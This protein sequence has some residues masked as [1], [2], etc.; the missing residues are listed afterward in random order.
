MATSRRHRPEFSSRPFWTSTFIITLITAYALFLRPAIQGENAHGSTL[1]KRVEDQECRL[2]H[3]AKDQCAFILANCQDDEAG[4]LQYL[5]FYYC[6][7]GNVQPLAFVILVVWMGMLFTTIGIA[8]S[9]FFS[10]NLSTIAS[11][12]GL[13]E[14]LAGVTFLAFGNGSPDV[15]STFAAMGSNSGSMAVGELIGAAGF[16][17]AV[18]AGSMALVR[19]F[20]VSRK[21]FVRDI[22]FFIAAVSFAM[23]FLADG[24]LNLWECMVMI[25]FYVFYVITVVGWHWLS[26]RRRRRR[27]KEAT[28]RSHFNGTGTSTDELEPYRDDPEDDHDD[29]GDGAPL[30]QRRSAT[31]DM[32]QL[33]RGPLISIIDADAAADEDAE[34]D[35]SR[36]ITAEMTSS[37]R[38]NRPLGRRSNTL[39]T[40]IRPSLV[41]VLEFRSIL[42]SLQKSGNVHLAPL[43]RSYTDLSRAGGD[44]S[45]ASLGAIDEADPFNAVGQGDGSNFRDRALSSGA[46]PL[47]L[48][49]PDLPPPEIITQSPKSPEETT[50]ADTLT[51]ESS[52]VR[53]AAPTGNIAPSLAA[54]LPDTDDRPNQSAQAPRS[55]VLQLQIPSPHGHSS[56]HSSPLGSPFPRF[57]ESP[58][59]MTGGASRTTTFSLPTPALSEHAPFPGIEEHRMPKPVRWWPYGILPPPHV[60]FCT[61]F[62]TLQGWREKNI[63]DKFVSIVSIPSIF[64]LVTTLPV[65]ESEADHDDDDAEETL[66]DPPAPG[67]PGR[68]GPPV[69]VEPH[70]SI[71]PE[72]EW[73][74][75]RRSTRSGSRPHSL[76]TSPGHSPMIAPVQAFSDSAPT[77]LPQPSI[78]PAPG[79]FSDPQDAAP[80]EPSGWNRWLVV[81]QLFTGPLFTVFII[82]ANMEESGRMLVKLVLYSLLFSL[83]LLAILLLTTSP[84]KRPKYHFLLCFLG[85]VISIAWI[86]TVAG[87]VVGVLKAFG[88][89][90]GISE[91]IL[92]LTIF[93]VGNS[94]GDLVADITV[95]RLGYPVMAL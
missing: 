61:L 89:I 26:V 33:E 4:L 10:V 58:M 55:P 59:P 85:F 94:V 14:S 95:A 90:V 67:S 24:I 44:R 73:Q 63:W 23:V 46:I 88:V 7:L 35:R 9:D 70:V 93:A 18:V 2:V 38:I 20:K 75:Y 30:G 78:K 13:S 84:D 91:A 79:L 40:P 45:F 57:V 29:P 64:L 37:M 83:V 36:H 49:N 65:V 1:A 32:G 22:C 69:S 34:E 43:R 68:M 48:D 16:I 74:R 50:A 42:S 76:H 3:G 82:W 5:T 19:E 60:L 8:A 66:A 25:G 77:S 56:N 15:F 81:L 27:A 62:P 86:S 71:A 12:L 17:T 11:I 28:S 31:V 39:I 52:G 51:S 54:T 72:T 41:G 6:T 53:P 47:N 92:G 21:T 80:E 87:E